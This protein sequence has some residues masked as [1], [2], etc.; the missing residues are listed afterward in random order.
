VT[1]LPIIFLCIYFIDPALKG[2]LRK[3]VVQLKYRAVQVLFMAVTYSQWKYFVLTG[4]S[5]VLLI[6][7]KTF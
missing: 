4:V 2:A 7:V 3:S 6:S 5:V 1:R